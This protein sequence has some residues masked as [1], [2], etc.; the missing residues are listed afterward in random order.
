MKAWQVVRSGAPSDAL[1]WCELERPVPLPAEVLVETRA[2]ALNY[3]EVDGCRGRYLTV[4]PPMPYTL[5]MEVVGTVVE[6]GPGAEEW[7]GRRVVAS[8]TNAFGAHAEFVRCGTSMVFDAPERLDD[9]DAAAF[10][11]PFHLAHLALHERG[12]VAA[13]DRVLIH[14]AAG[15]FGSAAVQLAKAAGA[16][17]IAVA[18]GA[19]KA[20]FVASLGADIVVDHHHEDFVDVVDRVTGG[21]GVDLVLDGVGGETTTRSIAAM[22]YD[23]TLMVV[24][25]ASGIEA[26]E[27]GVV[28]G[29]QLAFGQVSVGG[30][31]LSYTPDPLVAR[32][33]KGFNIT[34][35][36]VGDEVHRHLV[37]LLETDTIRPIVGEQVT[38]DQL[39]AA[40]ERM[41]ARATIGRTVVRW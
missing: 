9:T 12:H 19:R 34:P 41:E 16:T 13:G 31:M 1:D 40:L 14:A 4:N 11:F 21:H 5:G 25:F 35:R 10:F 7:L 22:G 18:G 2:T 23:A 38:V 17:V 8:A 32:R 27:T 29:R 28:T 3:N 26:E 20:E 37:E 24:G 15:G 39:P 30:V 33:Y 6:A 36:S